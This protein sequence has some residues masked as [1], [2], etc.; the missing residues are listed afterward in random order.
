MEICFL[1]YSVML[2]SFN[3][4]PDFLHISW[5]S[6]DDKSVA[7]NVIPSVNLL[8]I[9]FPPVSFCCNHHHKSIPI[10]IHSQ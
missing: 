9:A 10:S 2:L 3:Q 6:I 7:S 5:V 8:D 4:T 1:I